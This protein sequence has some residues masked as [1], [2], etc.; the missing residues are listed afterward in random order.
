VDIVGRRQRP[1]NTPSDWVIVQCKDWAEKAI[2]PAVLHR[3]CMLA[4][5]CQAVPVL[6][7][8][9]ELTK[10]A[11]HIARNWEVRVLEYPDLQRG[12]L[13]GPQAVDFRG[14]QQDPVVGIHSIRW[15]RDR[16]IPMFQNHPVPELSYVSG[17]E[18]VGDGTKYRPTTISRK[19]DG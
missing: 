2:P 11:A 1:H 9:S 16:M 12:S 18:P 14:R 7:H 19:D 4:F 3:L 17:Y 6:C 15:W 5:T 10:R 13:P 8:T